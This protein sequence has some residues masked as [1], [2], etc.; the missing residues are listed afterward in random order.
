MKLPHHQENEVLVRF[1]DS[2]YSNRIS[3]RYQ[4]NEVFIRFSDAEITHFCHLRHQPVLLEASG[5]T[6]IKQSSSHRA[7][8]GSGR[9]VA[10]VRC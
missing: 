3:F 4:E 5:P 9:S 2:E 10:Y 8:R 1:L 6:R 7:H